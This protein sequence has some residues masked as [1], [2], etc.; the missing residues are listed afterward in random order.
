MADLGR[1]RLVVGREVH[2]AARPRSCRTATHVVR[3]PVGLR[4]RPRGIVRVETGPPRE[5]RPQMRSRRERRR[6]F[7][8]SRTSELVM[9]WVR[10]AYRSVQRVCM[11][12][13]DG[14]A[15]RRPETSA[16]LKTW[17]PAARDPIHLPCA[18]SK[19]RS[20]NGRLKLCGQRRVPAADLADFS[21]CMR[22]VC[23]RARSLP[24]IRRSCNDATG[25]QARTSGTAPLQT[26][27]RAG[28]YLVSFFC[29]PPG[30]LEGRGSCRTFHIITPLLR[31]AKPQGT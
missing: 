1:R 2:R 6:A 20:F 31:P 10:C 13:T 5:D 30:R 26:R 12:V 14:L 4:P 18:T 25:R 19:G 22:D 21:A 9:P 3:T 27:H 17:P 28:C 23:A 15:V 7:R 29:I 24:D 11:S 16:N 8:S